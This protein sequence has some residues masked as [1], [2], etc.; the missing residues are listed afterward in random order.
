MTEQ[1]KQVFLNT[2]KITVHNNTTIVFHKISSLSNP[3]EIDFL[4]S[5]GR[6]G[7]LRYKY[8][9]LEI[10]V[11]NKAHNYDF[12]KEKY[13]VNLC[14]MFEP[15]YSL[16]IGDIFDNC[17]SWKVAKRFIKICILQM[18]TISI[19]NH[20]NKLISYSIE[21]EISPLEISF[22]LSDGREGY[23]R[24]RCGIAQVW[25][26]KKSTYYDNI[27]NMCNFEPLF[28]TNPCFS[29]V[30]GNKY[31]CSLSL[32]TAKSLIRQSLKIC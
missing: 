17:I 2:K 24:Y 6:N 21:H 20:S 11:F 1:F 25:I 3:T 7:L 19:T 14:M 4:L 5:D 26:Y 8:G 27:K 18:K 23:F 13:F 31:D 9:K 12:F 30:I 28:N 10:W 16:N 15:N 29:K 22:K 32:K